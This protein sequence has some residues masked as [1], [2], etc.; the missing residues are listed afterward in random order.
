MTFRALSTR[1]APL[2]PEVGLEEEAFRGD[3]TTGM[4][5]PPPRGVSMRLGGAPLID[6]GCEDDAAVEVDNDGKRPFVGGAPVGLADDARGVARTKSVSS[7][8]SSFSSPSSPS[9]SAMLL[10]GVARNG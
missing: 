3:S 9:P 6:P 8:S 4:S 1:P 7:A 5:L 10:S 2:P